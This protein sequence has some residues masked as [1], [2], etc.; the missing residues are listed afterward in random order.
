[1]IN[2]EN[3]MMLHPAISDVGACSVTLASGAS[4]P[5]HQYAWRGKDSLDLW[6]DAKGDW[7]ALKAVTPSGEIIT[8]EKL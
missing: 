4:Q 8:Y 7:S 3:G 5:A 1:M 2:P 6:Y